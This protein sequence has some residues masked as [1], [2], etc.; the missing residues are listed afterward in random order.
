MRKKYGI[1]TKPYGVRLESHE[2]DTIDFFLRIGKDVKV[3]TPSNT[4]RQTSPDIVVD[5]VLWEMKS[6]TSSNRRTIEKRIREAAHQSENIIFDLR[7]I[8]DYP[9]KVEKEIIRQYNL[10]KNIR[11]LVIIRKSGKRLDF[12]K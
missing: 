5:G 7:R 3:L 11:R 10:A 1:M 8:K 2:E 6:P 12:V 9:D 4:K